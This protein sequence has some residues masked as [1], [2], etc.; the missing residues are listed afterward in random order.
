MRKF[1]LGFILLLL[2]F[3]SIAYSKIGVGVGTGKIQVKDKLKPG[4]IYKLPPLTVL[5][6]GDEE[7]DYTVS[8]AYHTKQPEFMPEKDWFIF[9]PSEFHLKPGEVKVVDVKINLPVSTRPGDY[10]AYLEGRPTIKAKEGIT[11][12]G[13]AAAAKLYFNVVPA[14][15]FQGLYY[16]I[17]TFWQV[18]SPWTERAAILIGI[19]AFTLILKRFL[20][21][22]INLK[23][24]GKKINSPPVT[25]SFSESSATHHSRRQRIL[26]SKLNTKDE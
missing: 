4:M 12:I 26:E 19:I 1:L 16:K 13:I 9:A 21:I 25:K 15:I 14:N 8:V 20:N 11:T 24:S 7:S 10:F 5:N 18:Y 6:T 23:K 3:P 22:E 2:I 17:I